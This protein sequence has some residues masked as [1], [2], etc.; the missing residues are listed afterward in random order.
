MLAAIAQRLSKM[1]LDLCPPT[2][3]PPDLGRLCLGVMGLAP[4]RAGWKVDMATALRLPEDSGCWAAPWQVP[5]DA[6][7]PPLLSLNLLHL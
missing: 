4:H 1:G 7:R 5:A 2:S 3:S 6:R